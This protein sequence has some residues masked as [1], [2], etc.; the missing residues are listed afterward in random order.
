MHGTRD[1]KHGSLTREQCPIFTQGTQELANVNRWNLSCEQWQRSN[2]ETIHDR[3]CIFRWISWIV[4]IFARPEYVSYQKSMFCSSK[5]MHFFR[6]SKI[7]DNIC[8]RFIR[9]VPG[10][11]DNILCLEFVFLH[12]FV[13]VRCV[14]CMESGHSGDTGRLPCGELSEGKC[15][16]LI[17]W[18]IDF[19]CQAHNVTTMTTIWQEGKAAEA[20]FTSIT[21]T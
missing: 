5:S 3:Y 2:N 17:D 13:C 1:A 12:N 20:A 7:H 4:L 10:I 11:S 6:I 8:R 14:L 9:A 16:W 21:K 19:V 18:L 15:W